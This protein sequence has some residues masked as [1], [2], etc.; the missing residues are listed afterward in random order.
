[1]KTF[2]DETLYE[3][4]LFIKDALQTGNTV[5]IKVLNPAKYGGCYSG[6]TVLLQN[7]PYIYRSY[8]SYFEIADFLKLR[9]FVLGVEGD[10]MTL[11]YEKVDLRNSFHNIKSDDKYAANST[12]AKI[13]KNE[14]GGFL[15][16]FTQALLHCGIEHKRTILDLGIN[17]GDEF[18]AIEK[19]MGEKRFKKM[20]LTGID[21]DQS[22]I[23]QA[24]K[25]F[26]D[27]K[28]FVHDINDLSL[29]ADSK[30]DL[31]IS[32]GTLQSPAIDFDATLKFLTKN[33]VG[34]KGSI[35][36]GFPNARWIDGELFY[37]AK[38]KNYAFSE[39]SVV[40]KDVV[41]AK[42][43]LQQQKFRVT[44][45]GKEYLFLTAHKL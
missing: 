18:E 27:A 45:T 33:C 34:Q 4:V 44:V 32:I 10:F 15:L 26:P 24:R 8:K 41:F 39:M 7:V 43:Y 22:A 36:L 6:T 12:F 25:K 14:E 29:L 2:S 35:I 21:I 23:D 3:I 13:Y 17:S 1:M 28:F 38:A 19:V 11:G 37:G 40:L 16:Y 31:I 42:R 30:F 5:C 9:C 20:Q